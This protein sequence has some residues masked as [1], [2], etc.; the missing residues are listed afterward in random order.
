MKTKKKSQSAIEFMIIMIFVLVIIIGIMYVT[1]FISIDMKNNDNKAEI[2][3]FAKSITTEFELMSK[4]EGGYSRNIT[5]PSHLTKKFKPQINSSYLILTNTENYGDTNNQSFYYL[6]PANSTYTLTNDSTGE[7]YLYLTKAKI[8]NF[9]GILLIDN[10]FSNNLV[11]LN[12]SALGLA[13][14]SWITVPGNSALGTSDFC[15]MKYDAKNVGNVATS[16]SSLTPWVSIN[17]TDSRNNCSNLGSKY[18]L[19]TNAEWTTIARNAES[20]GANWNTS[21]V[22][23]GFMFSGHNDNGPAAALA[24]DTN[25]SNG[26]Y[27][28]NDNLSSCDGVYSNFVVGDDTTSG[29]ACAGQRRTL[30]LNNSEVIW[31]IGGNVWKWNNDTCGQGDP[32]YS[33]GGWIEWTYANI[34]TFEKTLGGPLGNYDASNSVGRYYGCTTA[35]NGFLR[36]GTWNDGEGAGAF[37]LYLD[38]APSNTY[39]YIGFRCSYNP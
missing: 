38:S 11:T 4:I 13:G 7:Y 24:A 32:W 39:T 3:D 14:G 6:L 12:C 22:G 33:T 27:L 31:D 34:N 9:E 10:P 26:Y 37:Y 35:G 30:V 5:I 28:T 23:S 18:H 29:R 16:Q 17:Q 25:D 20:V 19:I 2:D 36:S 8:D 21:V 1:S 15:V